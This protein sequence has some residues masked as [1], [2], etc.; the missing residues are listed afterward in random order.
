[1][2]PLGILKAST[3]NV[4]ITKKSTTETEKTL[5]HSQMK[6]SGPRR[7]LTSRRASVRCSG[8]IARAADSFSAEEGALAPSRESIGALVSII[9]QWLTAPGHRLSA[10]SARRN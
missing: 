6:P 10:A 8:V 2:L 4:R 5:V 9:E 7:R 3:K 1:M